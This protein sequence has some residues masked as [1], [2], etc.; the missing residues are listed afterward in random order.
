MREA[1][2]AVECLQELDVEYL[3]RI[4]D[5][6]NARN[7]EKGRCCTMRGMFVIRCI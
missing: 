6:M 1:L 7:V 5:A 4:G 2:E 3:K